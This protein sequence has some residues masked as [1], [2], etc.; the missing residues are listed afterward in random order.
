MNLIQ[1]IKNHRVS[2]LC[3]VLSNIYLLSIG[4]HTIQFW[5]KPFR[6]MVGLWLV[7][8]PLATWVLFL[9]AKRIQP[10]FNL[11]Y[12]KKFILFIIPAFLLC[13]AITWYYYSAPETF[14]T[15]TITPT[16][17][18]NQK[19]EIIE[20]KAGG[21]IIPP[22]QSNALK[23]SWQVVDDILVATDK[24]QPLTV[25]FKSKINEPVSVLFY[26]TPQGG[27]VNISFE[28]K[29]AEM[30]LKSPENRQKATSFHTEN[31]R[32]FSNWIFIPLLVLIDF[33]TIGS[34][35]LL[36][37]L[38]QET[39]QTEALTN[40]AKVNHRRNIAILLIISS[41]FHLLNALAVPLILDADSPSFLDGAIYW[42]KFGNLD[43]VSMVRGPGPAFLLAPFLYLFGR[44][45]WGIKIG[46]HLL[47]IACV[48]VSYRIGWQL[49]KNQWAALASGLVT[50]FAADLFLYANFLMSDLP[51]LF[52][53]LVFCTLLISA[54]ETLEFRWVFATMLMGS[55]T[56]LFRPENITLI[57]IGL[58]GIIASYLWQWRVKG[59]AKPIHDLSMFSLT[60]FVAVLPLLWWS[61]HNQRVN[62]FFGLSNYAGGIIY[63]GWVYFGDAS[64]LNFTDQNSQAVQKL[65]KIIDQYPIIITDK[66]GAPTGMEIYP[67]LIKSG[68]TPEQGFKLL[69]QAA[70]DS[71]KRDW[72]LTYKLLLIK[73]K[74][75]IRPETTHMLSL[76]LP[77]EDYQ[78]PKMGYFDQERLSIPSL[79]LGQRKIY[80]YIQIWYD[81]FFHWWIYACVFAIFFSLYRS[82]SSI[83]LTLILIIGTRIFIPNIMGLAHWR[84]TLAGLIPLQIIA[85]SWLVTIAYAISSFFRRDIVL[86]SKLE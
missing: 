30:D 63:D 74:T 80:K 19:V 1:F 38:L 6:I 82:P 53:V 73:I 49:G 86:E 45:P 79:I 22:S 75:S 17:V 16:T 18:Q 3:F 12:E 9:A 5:E 76:P 77:E 59:F 26:T 67:S 55:W 71:I 27:K 37:Y 51:N 15:I 84:Y 39:V 58:G 41:I 14:H 8:V 61:A 40:T 52:F 7:C 10:P 46:L 21:V 56:T 65:E 25:S 48:P 54:M 11:I 20:I 35:F 2:I 32:G 33:M 28:K 34:L 64:G 29:Q 78:T 81:S 62:G 69:E 68:Y 36:L 44:N 13:T 47:A 42:L 50:V 31:Y 4:H 85:V 57:L 23:Y 24:S 70:V 66:S 60:F 83:W 43:G 72:K